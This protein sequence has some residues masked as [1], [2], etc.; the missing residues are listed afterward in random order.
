MLTPQQI[1]R[2]GFTIVELLVVIVVI[3]ILASITIVSYSGI[4]Q[5]AN[6]TSAQ[7]TAQ[8]VVQ[9]AEVYNAEIGN[10]PYA[11]SDLTGDSSK[12]YYI[13]PTSFLF[14]LSTTQPAT[15]NIVKYVKCGT[16]PNSSQATI[17]PANN[18][19][20]GVRIYYWTYSG[21]PNANS[22]DTAGAD[23]GSGIACP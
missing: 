17:I 22:Y 4:T 10:Y 15:P 13:S 21:T 1:S 16:T 3:G 18:N 6:T 12:S 8:I 7:S 20:T 14:T 23:T 2:S 11:A 5:R 9:K 19:I